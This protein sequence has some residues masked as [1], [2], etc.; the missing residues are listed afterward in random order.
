MR[1]LDRDNSTNEAVIGKCIEESQVIRLALNDETSPYVIPLCFGH[2]VID[3]RRFFYFHKNRDGRLARML[4]SCPVCTFE[5]EGD[6]R[7][8]LDWEKMMCNMDYCSVIGR[9]RVS[10]IE[11]E[12]ERDHAMDVLMENRTVLVIAH[13]LSTIRNATAIM[14]LEKGNIIERGNHEELVQ[15]KGRYYSLYTGQFELE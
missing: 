14:V 9:G 6:T 10:L 12:A 8:F 13:R 4:E 15:Q 5:L 2:E 7:L 11:T 1:R 3:G